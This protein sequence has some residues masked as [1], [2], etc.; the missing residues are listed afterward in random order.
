MSKTAVTAGVDEETVAA[1]AQLADRFGCT[2]EHLVITA[3]L[4]FVEEERQI[5]PDELGDLPPYVDPDPLAR[6]LNEA[7]GRA[8]KALRAYL[9]PALDDLEGGRTVP[10]EDVMRRMRE[11]RRSRDAA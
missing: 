10:H 3:V 4:R 7:N 1:L 11:R 5:E 6:A 2:V 8:I 9:Q